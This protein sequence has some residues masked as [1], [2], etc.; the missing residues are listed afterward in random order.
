MELEARFE[1]LFRHWSKQ[2]Q[3][4]VEPHEWAAEVAVGARTLDGDVRG[5]RDDESGG[6]GGSRT[7]GTMTTRSR[8]P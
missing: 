1:K 4:V 7:V 8:Y 3:D 6:G 2:R 5:G